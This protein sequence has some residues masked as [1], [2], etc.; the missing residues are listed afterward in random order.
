[1]SYIR[2]FKRDA[3]RAN[4]L[5]VQGCC[6]SN[7]QLPSFEDDYRTASSTAELVWAPRVSRILKA[8]EGGTTGGEVRRIR[9]SQQ[10]NESVIHGYYRATGEGINLTVYRLR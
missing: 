8:S 10:V 5:H 3:R 9:W 1:M 4:A 7:P 2:N 6:P